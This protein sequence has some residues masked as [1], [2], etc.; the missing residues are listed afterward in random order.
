[1]YKDKPKTNN[2]ILAMDNQ[3]LIETRRAPALAALRGFPCVT[4]T[5]PPGWAVKRA[6]GSKARGYTYERKVAKILD[7]YCEENGWTLL[8]HQWFVY[9][10]GED[11][12]YFQPDFVIDRPGQVGIIAEVKLTYVDTTGQLQKYLEYLKFFGLVCFP[13]TIVRHLTPFI[14]KGLV[15]DDIKKIQP[16][17]I[18]HLWV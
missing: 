12:F 18:W 3:A 1:M 5:A 14:D 13:I 10:K 7:K 17:T 15:V 2:E 8:D 11:T 16:N 6:F 9:T 4:T